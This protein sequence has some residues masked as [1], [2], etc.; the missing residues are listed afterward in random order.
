[1]VAA[2]KR[3]W[4]AARA[5][6]TDGGWEVALD[7]RPLR[8]PGR[9]HLL[10]P[11]EGLARAIAAEWDAV[12]DEVQPDAVPLTGLANAALDIV[13]ADKPG[14]AASLAL[15]AASDLTC[16]RAEGPA[17]LVARQAAR[18]EPVLKEV[19]ARHGLLFRRT[20]GVIHV[21]QPAETLAA[22]EALLAGLTPF[23]LAALQ[24][25]VTIGG[26][27]VLAL[28]HLQGSLD[29]EAAFDASRLDEDWQAEQWG[30]DA[31]AQSARALRRAEYEAAARFLALSRG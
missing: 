11:A 1:M 20:S 31:E 3:F 30:A 16:Y 15:Y 23:E 21:E 8:T 19:E 29:W 7:G 13:S 6:E 9:A 22:V 25:M 17:T 18:W 27:A 26:S 14:F 5:Q 10:L 4:Q 12:A 28:A 2:L 24:P